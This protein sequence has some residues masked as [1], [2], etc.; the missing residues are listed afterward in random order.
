MGWFA[1]YAPA[2]RP[3]VV[4]VVFVNP[5][6]GHLAS[7]VAGRIYQ[8]LYKPARRVR[9]GRE[10]YSGPAAPRLEQRTAVVCDRVA[11]V[12]PM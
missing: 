4:I 9:W 1:S 11:A 10:L 12:R 5:G 8:H 7:A 6:S 3:E 2:D